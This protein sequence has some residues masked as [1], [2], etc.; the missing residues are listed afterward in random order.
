MTPDL[1]RC[2]YSR[3]AEPRATDGGARGSVWCRA[4][5]G[6]H[7]R[8]CGAMAGRGRVGRDG[9]G[10]FSPDAR[11]PRLQPGTR[12]G[13]LARAGRRPVVRRLGVRAPGVRC[14]LSRVA[15][16]PLRLHEP[17][18]PA[19]QR[20]E[21]EHVVLHSCHTPSGAPRR[22]R[23]PRRCARSSTSRG[24]RSPRGSRPIPLRRALASRG[25]AP[26][27]RIRRAQPPRS[28]IAP[29]KWSAARSSAGAP[30]SDGDSA[31]V[32]APVRNSEASAIAA[33][34]PQ[35]AAEQGEWRALH[36]LPASRASPAAA[37]SAVGGLRA[38][39]F[40]PVTEYR[41]VLSWNGKGVFDCA[42]G[43]WVGRDAQ[44]TGGEGYP[45]RSEGIGPHRV[46]RCSTRRDRW[47]RGAA[48]GDPRWHRGRAV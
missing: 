30:S 17:D 42:A 15:C 32:R 5:R 36:V 46:G 4:A 25:S 26:R 45:D 2:G 33:A 8:R 10:R 47:R 39:G 43:R 16:A 18:R 28:S 20:A 9:G 1:I 24:L 12:E 11:C 41:L 37:E 29:P 23:S 14:P 35:R 21:L 3:A 22:L 13:R 40:A 38:A 27:P 6:H 19:S 48:G 31:R 44:V 7:A 34:H